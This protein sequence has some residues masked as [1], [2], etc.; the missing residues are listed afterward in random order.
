MFFTF[1]ASPSLPFSPSRA[2][3]LQWAS[4]EWGRYKL[5]LPTSGINSSIYS[6]R[7]GKWWLYEQELTVIPFYR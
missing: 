3:P 5:T 4:D 7:D 6:G 2:P 1:G